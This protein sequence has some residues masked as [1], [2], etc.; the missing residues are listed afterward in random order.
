[1]RDDLV[2]TIEQRGGVAIDPGS[3]GRHCHTRKCAMTAITVK[4]MKL[5]TKICETPL[6]PSRSAPISELPF[7]TP[8]MGI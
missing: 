1:M 6:L 7:V 2:H 8:D 3:H 5:V 4:T